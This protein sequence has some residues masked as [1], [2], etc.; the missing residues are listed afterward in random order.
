MSKG[1]FKVAQPYTN[2][3]SMIIQVEGWI[4]DYKGSLMHEGSRKKEIIGE[5]VIPVP[6]QS[7]LEATSANHHYQ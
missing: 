1:K 4:Y 3:T 7:I 6:W 5:W 2:I